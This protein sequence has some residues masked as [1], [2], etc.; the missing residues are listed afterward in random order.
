MSP[1]YIAIVGLLV[2]PL[3]LRVSGLAHPSSGIE[4]SFRRVLHPGS[5]VY[6]QKGCGIAS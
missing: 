3:F 4:Q 2:G 5:A 1:A 6:A